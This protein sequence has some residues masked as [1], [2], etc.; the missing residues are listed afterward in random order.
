MVS[1]SSWNG[2]KITGNQILLT[3]VLQGPAGLRRLRR[4]ATGTPTARSP[5]CTNDSCAQ[6]INAGLDMFMAPDSWKA[7]YDNTLAQARSGEIPAARLDDAVRRIL[8]V[9]VKAGLFEPRRASGRGAIRAVLGSPEHRA[10]AREAVRESL[11]LLKNDGAVLPLRPGARVLVAGDGADDIGR[12][13][14]A[15]PSRWQ[16]TGNTN[17]DFPG[18]QSIWDGH[19]ARR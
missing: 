17:A 6:A 13:P 1:F 16:G 11:V 12:R 7:L 2:V 3:D 14:A 8:R 5:G 19:R 18:G 15:G 10:L 9:K 4:S